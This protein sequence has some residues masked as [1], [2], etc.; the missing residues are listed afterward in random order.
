L[1]SREALVAEALTVLVVGQT[2]PPHHGQSIMIEAM[3]A[4]TYDHIRFE[5]IRM[6][7]SSTIDEVGVPSAG[8]ALQ[9]I[10]VVGKVLAA[11]IRVRP[12]VLYY[13]PAGPN[14]VPVYRDIALL[15]TTRRLFPRTV[16]H[17][18][19]GGLSEFRPTLSRT[20]QWLYDRA[21][22][23]PDLAIS[24]SELNP[25]DGE[26]LGARLTRTIPYGIDDHSQLVDK[27]STAHNNELQIL[28]VGAVREAK[29]VL[30]LLE[31]LKLLR[32]RRLTFRA[33]LVG[34]F[35]SAAFE[36]RARAVVADTGLDKQVTFAGLLT[37]HDKWQAYARA[38][39]FCFPTHYESESFGVVL[40]EAM[41]F[42]LPVVA[43]K[44]RGVPSIVRDGV[45]GYLVEPHD[46]VAVADRLE[47][48]LNDP[49][50][51][52]DLGAAGRRRYLAEFTADVWHRRMEE[53]LL[54][55]AQ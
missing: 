24:L 49:D 18:H 37:A 33:E 23:K 15:L 44:W 13:P 28:F 26:R 30:V 8:K 14:R 31:A 7:F 4:G 42:S 16:F 1:C 52:A 6:E 34:P 32:E 46:A 10:K 51:R 9:L 38:D 22:G 19:A 41:Q 39:V 3:L 25:P 11:R 55:A 54:Q 2:P 20:G 12:R 17:F 45:T 29:G 5:H 40:L 43:S 47:L 21:Y 53:A 50:L 36:A 27:S 35:D 48:L